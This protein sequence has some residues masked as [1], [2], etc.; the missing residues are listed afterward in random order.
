VSRYLDVFLPSQNYSQS[1]YDGT[2]LTWDQ[3][4][5]FWYNPTTKVY[6]LLISIGVI[7]AIAYRAIIEHATNQERAPWKGKAAKLS[8]TLAVYILPTFCL[9][10][11][12]NYSGPS[13]AYGDPAPSSSSFFGAMMKIHQAQWLEILWSFSHFLAAVGDIPQYRKYYNY[14]KGRKSHDWWL[15]SSFFA[16][17]NFRHFYIPHWIIR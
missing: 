14:L 2:T 8:K 16:T 10:Y 11:Q 15:M 3:W 5:L 17:V 6:L 4:F 7:L 12:F 13:N 1:Q 9:A